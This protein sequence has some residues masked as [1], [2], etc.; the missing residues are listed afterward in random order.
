MGEYPLSSGLWRSAVLPMLWIW[1]GPLLLAPPLPS[2][3]CTVWPLAFSGAVRGE[4]VCSQWCT[5]P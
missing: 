1:I 5:L 3:W 2:C 4:A